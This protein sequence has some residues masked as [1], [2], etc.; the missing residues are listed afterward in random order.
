MN[1][2]LDKNENL[3]VKDAI[4]LFQKSP[5]FFEL[6]EMTKIDKQGTI[7][8]VRSTKYCTKIEREIFGINKKNYP[9]I[10]NIDIMIQNF[11]PFIHMEYPSLD[12][13]TVGIMDDIVNDDFIN[14]EYKKHKI[15]QL[16]FP[17]SR[18]AYDIFIAS[19]NNIINLFKRD[20]ELYNFYEKLNGEPFDKILILFDEM[21]KIK[22]CL[23][24]IEIDRILKLKQKLGILKSDDISD[25]NIIGLL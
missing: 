16:S 5:F 23:Y 6:K 3:T 20:F 10:L 15:K 2:T 7:N 11:R 22:G 19:Y 4:L 24:T 14:P 13:R 17:F 21:L 9:I 8:M 12:Y 25:E 18:Y 1:E